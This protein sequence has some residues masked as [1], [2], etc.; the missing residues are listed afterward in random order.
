MQYG[1]ECFGA[2]WLNKIKVYFKQFKI[3]PDRAGK[4][5]ASLRDSQ[6]IWSIIEGFE[7]NIN[8]K[9]WLQ[10]QPI[11]MMGKTSDLFVLMDK[12]IERG[13]GL[14]A[15]ISANQRLSEIPST[16]LL[17]LLDIV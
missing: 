7:D 2:E 9:Y 11:A 16:T 10:K 5:L 3:T 14:A 15:I 4:I 17:Y 12:Y 13:R 8:E 6:E 1:V